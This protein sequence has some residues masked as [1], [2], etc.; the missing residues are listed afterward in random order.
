MKTLDGTK[1]TFYQLTTSE[2]LALCNQLNLSFAAI[3][4][5]MYLRTIN[6]W[7]DRRVEAETKDLAQALTLHIRTIQ[8]ALH[9]L[10]NKG[11][12]EL[13]ITRFKFS[14][15]SHTTTSTP[16]DDQNV[17]TSTPPDDQNVATDDIYAATDDMGVALT[18]ST[19][20]LHSESIDAQGFQEPSYSS[21]SS[22]F[23]D[24]LSLNKEARIERESFANASK[25]EEAQPTKPELPKQNATSSKKSSL[26][27]GQ[28]SAPRCQPVE[29]AKAHYGDVP[30]HRRSWEPADY[31]PGYVDFVLE[32]MR[33]EY[34]DRSHADAVAA[35]ENAEANG[36][37][38]RIDSR[39]VEWQTA[40]QA[41]AAATAA[42]TIATQPKEP[43]EP[44]DSAIARLMAQ[45]NL[46]PAEI[47]GKV[48]SQYRAA[49]LRLPSNPQEAWQCLS[50]AQKSIIRTYL[51]IQNAPTS[52][53]L[54]PTP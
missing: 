12:I 24:S 54:A 10:N 37:F 48:A 28:G 18:T 8:R 41:K 14:L 35:I 1:E 47:L 31:Q 43:R 11:L 3:K 9:E 53:S 52:P 2:W 30:R 21:Y 38:G 20:R 49:F 15:K 50:H 33:R 34:G 46:D 27:K 42:Q 26:V 51:E 17:A 36:N 40:A 29:N 19:P 23:K 25:S 22:D 32:K 4:V 13:E 5:L 6:P 45:Q 44:L 39:C 7:G 16:P